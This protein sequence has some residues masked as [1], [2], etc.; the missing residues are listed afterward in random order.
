MGRSV[1][2]RN[3][4]TACA[5]GLLRR[6][7]VGEEHLHNIVEGVDRTEAPLHDLR[8]ASLILRDETPGIANIKVLDLMEN[9]L[10]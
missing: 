3:C 10:I 4:K 6:D 8:E 1:R 2:Q 9:A 7:R 5:A